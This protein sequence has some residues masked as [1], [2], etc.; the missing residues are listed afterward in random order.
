MKN[1]TGNKQY[2]SKLS[3]AELV[4][5]F[6]FPSAEAGTVKQKQEEEEFWLE[7]RKQFASR[8]SRQQV[9]DKLLQLKF[10]LEAYVSSNQYQGGLNFGYFLNEYVNRQDKQDK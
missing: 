4:D 7:R 9:Y 8:T 2:V 3:S 6:I 5:V 1:R 10:R